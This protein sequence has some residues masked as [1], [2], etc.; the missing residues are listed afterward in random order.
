MVTHLHDEHCP[1]QFRCVSKYI[2]RGVRTCGVTGDD[3]N[4][5]L[6]LQG[7]GP[8]GFAVANLSAQLSV[9]RLAH[10]AK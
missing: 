3:I 9:F 10:V 2:A 6:T 5:T 7:H 8:L 1:T 4:I